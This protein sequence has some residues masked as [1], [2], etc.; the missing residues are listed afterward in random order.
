MHI[1]FRSVFTYCYNH[2]SVPLCIITKIKW[3]VSLIVHWIMIIIIIKR[4]RVIIF[5][6]RHDVKKN[7]TIYIF[8]TVFY[9][10]RYYLPYNFSQ[11]HNIINIAHYW[12]VLH[13]TTC[14]LLIIWAN[15]ITLSKN[16]MLILIFLSSICVSNK[17][18]K[19]FASTK[20]FRF[21]FWAVHVYTKLCTATK[22]SIEIWTR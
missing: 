21:S 15:K 5:Q 18:E 10:N 14:Q 8:C 13:N 9:S 6:N 1:R 3:P 17:N 7:L 16:L 4:A 2:N 20:M 11:V 22:F 12:F 19:L